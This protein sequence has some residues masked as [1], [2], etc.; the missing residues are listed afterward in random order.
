MGYAFGLGILACNEHWTDSNGPS[1]AVC[2]CP[3]TDMTAWTCQPWHMLRYPGGVL[4]S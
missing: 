4:E 2:G 3:R 1:P